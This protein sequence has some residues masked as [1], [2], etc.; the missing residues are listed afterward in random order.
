MT[1]Q[2]RRN[3]Q[4]KALQA[5]QGSFKL[6]DEQEGFVIILAAFRRNEGSCACVSCGR[7]RE[8]L[9]RLGCLEAMKYNGP[10]APPETW[11]RLS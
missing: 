2:R 11:H 10:W 4:H 7:P 5:A 1:L 6:G 9:H 8:K 3:Q